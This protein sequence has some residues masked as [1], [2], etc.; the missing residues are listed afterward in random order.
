MSTTAV[1]ERP[2][3]LTIIG[4]KKLGLDAPWTVYRWELIEEGTWLLHLAE[5]GEFTKGPRKGKA[6]W[7]KENR[8]ATATLVDLRAAEAEFE[9]TGKC[10][11]CGGSGAEWAGWHHI[12][13][14][15]YKECHRCSGTGK[16]PMA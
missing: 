11:Q 4:R 7:G 9:A 10:H 3:F 16:P 15:R 2:D 6:K 14:T 13:G 8:R 5:Q 1:S 12:T